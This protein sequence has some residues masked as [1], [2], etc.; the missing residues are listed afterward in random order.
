MKLVMHGYGHST[1]E[2]KD[3]ALTQKMDE[4]EERLIANKDFAQPG[5][6]EAVFQQLQHR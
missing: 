1:N 4:R 2:N 6:T 3:F 5:L